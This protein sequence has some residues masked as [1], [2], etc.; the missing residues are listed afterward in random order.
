MVVV[1]VSGDWFGL[2]VEDW[3]RVTEWIW[4]RALRRALYATRWGHV[5]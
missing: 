4:C 2:N 5:P 3:W 1:C